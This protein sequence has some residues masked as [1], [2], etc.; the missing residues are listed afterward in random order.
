MIE[1][2]DWWIEDLRHHDNPLGMGLTWI[3]VPN[4]VRP[5]FSGILDK[6]LKDLIKYWVR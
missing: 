2:L 6:E 3:K 5:K 1:D 4:W